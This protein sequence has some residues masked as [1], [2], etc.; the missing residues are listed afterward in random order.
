MQ[1]VT[2]L[3]L[4]EKHAAHRDSVEA[5]LKAHQKLLNK[6]QVLSVDDGSKYDMVQRELQREFN[7]CKKTFLNTVSSYSSQQ[8]VASLNSMNTFFCFETPLI[9]MLFGF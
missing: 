2:F 5:L 1:L 6:M 9:P 4:D 8:P 7:E 3:L